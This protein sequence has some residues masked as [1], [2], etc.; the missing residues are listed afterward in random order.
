MQAQ[1]P[2]DRPS[3]RLK[4]LRQEL[5]VDQKT[6]SDRFRA[7]EPRLPKLLDLLGSEDRD[8]LLSHSV[9]R[10]VAKGQA[11]YHQGD[12]S[13]N[14]FILKSG[15][16]KVHYITDNGGSLTTSYYREG[17]LFGAHG[18]TEWAGGHSWSAQALVDSRLLW[19]RRSK[20]LELVERSPEALRAVLA[21]SEF[22]GALLRTIIRI[23][24]EP[25]LERRIVMALRHLG[26]L[27]GIRRGDEI[28]IA[29][30][31]THQEIAEMVG[32]SR[33]SVT[34]LLASLEKSDYVRREGRRL[35]VRPSRE[36]GAAD[37]RAAA[38]VG[39]VAPSRSA[40]SVALH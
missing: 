13:D 6:L 35:F 26:E 40:A 9:E 34:T 7:H 18:C 29:G 38:L 4:Q 36:A 23:L 27:Y 1:G 33:Q 37:D 10:S 25:A 14:L 31:F 24:A 20:Y 17:M 2:H 22:K 8:F 19:I 16:V 11:L 5:T 3:C 28:E 21:V 12:P 32:A 30:R 39:V 15:A